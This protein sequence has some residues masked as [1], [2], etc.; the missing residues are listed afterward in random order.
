M[1]TYNG[2]SWMGCSV[3]FI[4][5]LLFVFFSN[6]LKAIEKPNI[7]QMQSLMKLRN[8]VPHFFEKLFYSTDPVCVAYLG[9]SITAGAGASKPEL[10]YRSRLTS[11][12]RDQFPNHEI[13]EVNAAL[14]GTGSFLGAFRV[15]KDCIE[16]NPDL[17][18][19]EFAVN[20]AGESEKNCVAYMEGI[21]RQIWTA[22][23][24]TDIVFIYTTTENW[25]EIYKNNQMP[26]SVSAQEKLADYYGIP[27]INVGKSAAL[28]VNSGKWGK[29]EFAS[30]GVHP[31]DACYEV[32]A[33]TI[34][35]CGK[36]AFEKFD[37]K[38]DYPIKRIPL[39][40]SL[41]AVP[42]EP[43]RMIPAEN[44]QLKGSWKLNVKSPSGYF[45][46]VI[47]SET[48]GD[49]I[50]LNFTGSCIGY[51]DVRGPDS[52]TITYSIDDND[53]ITLENFDQW[54]KNFSRSHCVKLA[55]GLAQSKRHTLHIKIADSQPDG[56]KGKFFR[57]GYFL[58]SSPYPILPSDD[59]IKKA[60]PLFSENGE[61]KG[62]RVSAWDDV[63]KVGPTGAKWILKD[64]I[65]HGSEP[66]GTWLISEKIYRD[67]YIEFE[68]LLPERGNSGF[69]IRFSDA[70]DPAFDGME[71]QMCDP[72]YYTMSGYG[73]NPGELTG[74]VYEAVLPRVDM[75]LPVE[76]NK[77]QITCR[78]KDIWIVLNG[79]T[80]S[81]INLNEKTEKLDRGLPLS[82]RPREGHI[83]FQELSRGGGQVLIRNAKI[84]EFK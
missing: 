69:G 53:W 27:S 16:Q 66:R 29:R 3:L 52:G 30:D 23:P 25:F 70:G 80:L 84:Y 2:N 71:I 81:K 47:E 78:G 13:K 68:F 54:A 51:F 64:G 59:V 82:E 32:Y 36:L 45:P 39:I 7:A 61:P 43:A 56:S 41:S 42:L 8:G 28:M 67:F 31:T 65:L 75:Y 49:E 79:E 6:P 35:E 11:F 10:C 40:S 9:G 15:N 63:S 50:V 57:P 60:K 83:G 5:L 17:V 48:P 58:V 26:L 74:S 72:R 33:D 20:D 44:A 46:S 18:L 21:V 19:I 1:K 62:W 24:T 76:W 22:K 12:L 77:Y 55:E 34:V 73:Y 37:K 4:T 14:G 38:N